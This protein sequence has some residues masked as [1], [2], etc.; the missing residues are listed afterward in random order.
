MGNCL[1]RFDCF[2]ASFQFNI[3]DDK[4]MKQSLCGGC[5]S[6]IIFLVGFIYF[7]IL[8]NEWRINNIMPKIEKKEEILNSDQNFLFFNPEMPQI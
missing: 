2:N 3:E 4:K 1:K 5:I 8:I 7:I 6:I